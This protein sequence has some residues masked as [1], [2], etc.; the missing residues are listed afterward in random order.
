MSPERTAPSRLYGVLWYAALATA[1]VGAVGVGVRW[2]PE[3]WWLV[4]GGSGVLVAGVLR[5]AWRTTRE[6]TTRSLGRTLTILAGVLALLVA[7]VVSANLLSLDLP[8]AARVV[9]LATGAQ[10]FLLAVDVRLSGAVPY[11]R[12]IA[13]VVGHAAVIVGSTVLLGGNLF[14]VRPRAALLAYAGGFSALALHAFWLRHRVDGVAPPRPNT[15]PRNWEGAL[16]AAVTVAML[17]ASVVSFTARPV[18]TALV[19]HPVAWRV[20][21]VVAG[22]AAI[23]A[24]ATLAAPPTP[25]RVLSLLSGTAATVVQHAVAFVV[26]VNTLV[27]A[28]LFLYPESALWVLGAYLGV[29]LLGVVLE[30]LTVAYAHRR[31][32]DDRTDPPPLPPDAPVTVVVTAANE[33][34]VLPES[35]ES[36]LA[37]LEGLSFL[38]VPA[39][40]STDGT[41][42][43]AR[44]FSD[45][46]P[47]RVRVV[48]GTTG[49]KAGDLNLAW[50]HVETPYALILDADETV[51]PEFVAR[52]LA[53]LRD[54]QSVGVVQGRKVATDPYTS[55][56]A[57]FVSADRRYSTW[58]EHPFMND[59]FGASHFAGSGALLRHEVP[60]A[61]D[62]WSAEM[63]TEDIDLT[64]RLYLQT[65][66]EVAYVPEMT[67][68]DLNPRSIPGLIRQRVRWS[69]GWVQVAARH[70]PS[71][72]R[73]DRVD[74]RRTA[75]LSWLL[76]TAVSAPVYLV[77]PALVLVSAVGLGA[78]LPALVTL[79][80]GAVL[81][82]ARGVAIG[83][84]TLRD[85]TIPLERTPKRVV[86]M[87]VH[88][89][90]WILLGW[91]LQ[92]HA[93]YLQ[94]AGAPSVWHVTQKRAASSGDV[95]RRRGDVGARPDVAKGD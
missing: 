80:L 7:V 92:L 33:V 69:R 45:R 78:E 70:W 68:E 67:V 66:W 49:S 63:L 17:G 60:P 57:R 61:V 3:G 62:G 82:P 11:E 23:V 22:V 42:E 9:A 87:V 21:G 48:S 95:R 73:S 72:V 30:Y 76:F 28:V 89:Y 1:L 64:V 47:E 46:Y 90:A 44:T 94:L 53:V 29:L 88:A 36:N 24:L 5:T 25:P 71:L 84:A 16:L 74:W 77:F 12:L 86:E 8:L 51:G 59:V 15:M 35:L 19:P 65:D 14:P 10:A 32:T 4:T 56:L 37:A 6:Q 38:L 91:V 34:E 79:V 20:A 58:I 13:P 31:G 83:Y 54:R 52:G 26:L 81:L 93:L 39:S 40:K 41:A 27:L 55:R 85:P 18:A 2:W 50:D 75:G 43:I